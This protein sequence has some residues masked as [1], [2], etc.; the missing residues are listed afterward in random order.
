MTAEYSSVL[1]GDEQADPLP[2]FFPRT[3]VGYDENS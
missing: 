3:T 1:N 2:R